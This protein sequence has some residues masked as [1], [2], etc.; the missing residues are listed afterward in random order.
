MAQSVTVSSKR[1]RIGIVL[2]LVWWIPFWLLQPFFAV[3]FSINSPQGQS[4][5]L[6]GILIVQT[7]VGL[8]GLALVGKQV[9]AIMKHKSYRQIFP[10]VWH[11]VIHGT[12]DE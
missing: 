10:T 1:L 4:R 5:L 2:L 7:I 8:I 6:I 11:A 9:A 12:I 3:I